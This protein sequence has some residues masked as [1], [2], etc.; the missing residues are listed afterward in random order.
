MVEEIL[1]PK[2]RMADPGGPMKMIFCLEAARESGRRGFS[3]ACP[4]DI[5]KGGKATS[6]YRWW[7]VQYLCELKKIG[8]TK[9]KIAVL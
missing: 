5:L 6:Q 2:D 1:S 3:D 7:L 8:S 9:S 4:L